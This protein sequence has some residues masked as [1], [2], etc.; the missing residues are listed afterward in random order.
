MVYSL[1]VM[2]V[3]KVLPYITDILSFVPKHV[4][5]TSRTLIIA[6][7]DL[8][9]TAAAAIT[10]YHKQ[11]LINALISSEVQPIQYLQC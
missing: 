6:M 4:C 11:L 3:G 5:I 1:R 10:K 2:K 7:H 9:R 8:S